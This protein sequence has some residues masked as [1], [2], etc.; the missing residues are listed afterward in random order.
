[1]TFRCA[2]GHVA[3]MDSVD[4]ILAQWRRER[5]ELDVAPMG[6][7]GR[8]VRLTTHLRREIE[9]TLARHGL[10]ASSFDIL[11]TLR[12]AGAPYRLSPGDLLA[13]AMVTSGT[14][15]NR[16]DQLEKIGLVERLP[17]PEDGRG[18][19]VALTAAGL[20]RVEAAVTAHVETQVRLTAE[21]PEADRA[22]LDALLRGWLAHFE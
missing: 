8:L 19:L 3:D 14:M 18:V 1:L 15:T 2:C 4:A 20:E 16:I 22:A 11:A 6:L 12:R 21:M 13:T 17:N 7:F 9:H 5:P 10:T